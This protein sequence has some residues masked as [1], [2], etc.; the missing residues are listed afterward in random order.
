MSEIKT[1]SFIFGNEKEGS[2]PSL[3]GTGEKGPFYVDEF[4]QTH[5]GYPPPRN[6]KF[7]DAPFVM[8][9]SI[10][11]FY[12]HG[13]GK[14]VESRSELKAVDSACGTITSDRRVEPSSVKRERLAKEAKA[15]RIEHLKEVVQLVD[16]GN[17]P[18]TDDLKQRCKLEN[19]RISKQTGID[20]FNV[21]GRKD[22]KWTSK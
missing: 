5:P 22:T 9:D 7:G 14:M 18:L 1:K 2:W 13:A 20:A 21:A 10:T 6:V 12:H 16:S 3:Y 19:E 11:P 15:K 17:A 8:S 4:G